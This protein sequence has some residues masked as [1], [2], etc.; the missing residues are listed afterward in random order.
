V[1]V[2]HPMYDPYHCA[3]RLASILADCALP[4]IEWERLRL[5]DFY[6]TF[7]HLLTSI[8]LPQELRSK[9]RAL[10]SVPIPY[11]SLPTPKRLFFQLGII[12]DI[13]AKLLAAGGILD[14]GAFLNGRILLPK[15]DLPLT[16]R[17]LMNSLRFRSSDWYAL[18]TEELS[19]IALYGRNGLKE[20]SGLM[21][22]RHDA[23]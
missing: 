5:L 19:R 1:L 11:E 23:V 6:V 15:A 22:F 10:R 21:E 9:K 8:R 4:E 7:P 2:Y 18:V 20:R 17:E 16:F 3:L 13:A 14:R 12:Q